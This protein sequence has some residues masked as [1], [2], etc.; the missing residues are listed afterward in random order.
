MTKYRLFGIVGLVVAI[1]MIITGCVLPLSVG[2]TV[3]WTIAAVSIALIIT[4]IIW[5]ARLG[6]LTPQNWQPIIYAIAATAGWIGS[7]LSTTWMWCSIWLALAVCALVMLI[8]TYVL[9]HLPKKVISP[10][11]EETVI[12]SEEV[13]EVVTGDDEQLQKL[14]TTLRYKYVEDDPR[15]STS[16]DNP[17]CLVDGKALTVYE[18]AAGGHTE[19]AEEGLAYIKKVYNKE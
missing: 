19:A 11:G 5:K 4:E 13:L 10:S 17:L 15:G 3:S 1:A 2:Y 18:A 9:R 14:V 7:T 6:A 12:E 16:L 8:G